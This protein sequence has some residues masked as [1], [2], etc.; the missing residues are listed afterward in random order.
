MNTEVINAI[1]K[2]YKLLLPF[3]DERQ[4][5]LLLAVDADMLGHGGIFAV[6]GVRVPLP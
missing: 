6:K 3:L 2:R 1:Q 5:H 4:K